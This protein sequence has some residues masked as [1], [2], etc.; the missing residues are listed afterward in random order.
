MKISTKSERSS[1]DNSA[2][3]FI[4]ISSASL[5]IHKGV[6]KAAY[7]HYSHVTHSGLSLVTRMHRLSNCIWIVFRFHEQDRTRSYSR[8]TDMLLKSL[9]A[10]GDYPIDDKRESPA[11]SSFINPRISC[12]KWR[13]RYFGAVDAPP[14]IKRRPRPPLMQVLNPFHKQAWHYDMVSPDGR[15]L[16]GS[17]RVV[18]MLTPI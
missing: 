5:S 3:S 13:H 1:V 8:Q 10:N 17:V 14:D 15:G 4:Q 2:P 9:F 18:T 12:I 6:G 11:T 16:K 7:S